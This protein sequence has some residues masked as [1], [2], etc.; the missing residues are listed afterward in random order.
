MHLS[1]PLM[2]LITGLIGSFK[3]S[4]LSTLWPGG[5]LNS[6]NTIVYAIYQNAFGVLQNGLCVLDGYVLFLI[7]FVITAVQ[8][9]VQGIFTA[10]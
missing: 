2:C 3:S 4:V 5:P 9:R 7:T 10:D 6:T 1:Q 8:W